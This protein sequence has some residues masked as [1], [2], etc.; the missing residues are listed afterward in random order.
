[1]LGVLTRIEFTRLH[2]LGLLLGPLLFEFFFREH[3]V[4]MLSAMA[5]ILRA[6]IGD[7]ALAGW[8]ERAFDRRYRVLAYSVQ[9]FQLG[10]FEAL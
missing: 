3:A 10:L 6:A 9:A 8:R 7:K 5:L 4:A 1:M 2:A